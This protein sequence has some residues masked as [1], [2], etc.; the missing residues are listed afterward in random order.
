MT[1]ERTT[2]DIVVLVTAAAA[3]EAERIATALVTERLAACVNIVGPIRSIY[4][5]N[6][7]VQHDAELLLIIKTRAALFAALDVRV[8]ALH[9][10]ATPEII[11]LP[12]TAGAAAY[13]DWLHEATAPA[14]I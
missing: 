5:W 9:S 10:Y 12:I 2:G 14:R 4:R 1:T 7:Q 13:V 8:R 11:A 6:D 3:E